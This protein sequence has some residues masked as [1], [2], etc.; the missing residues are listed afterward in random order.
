MNYNV[1]FNGDFYA[2]DGSVHNISEFLAVL[3]NGGGTETSG[4]YVPLVSRDDQGCR[5]M[6]TPLPDGALSIISTDIDSEN[7]QEILAA[8]GHTSMLD[9]SPFGIYLTLRSKEGETIKQN[10][11]KLLGSGLK[12]NS[13]DAVLVP[14]PPTAGTATLQS[15]DGVLQWV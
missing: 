11:I 10:S 2:A 8:D 4:D 3:G 15:I 7:A 9:M 13:A 6:I 1:P 14:L 5:M 12:W